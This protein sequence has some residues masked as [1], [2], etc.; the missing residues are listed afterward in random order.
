MYAL[1]LWKET[2]G[3]GFGEQNKLQ[4]GATWILKAIFISCVPFL[5]QNNV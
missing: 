2:K 1:L 3:L 4:L 5:C